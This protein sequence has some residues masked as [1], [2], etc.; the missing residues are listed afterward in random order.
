ME[1]VNYSQI[2]SKLTK[3]LS[4][5][6]KGIFDKRFGVNPGTAHTLEAIGQKLGITRERVRQIEE[7]G[8]NYIRK[9]NKELLDK[10][11]LQ[12]ESYFDANGG[13]KKE[14]VLMAEL[15]GEKN[16]PY[17]LF[18]LSIGNQ[19]NKACEKKENY[20]FWVAHPKNESDIKGT[21]NALVA[22]IK[23]HGK[24]LSKNE[25]AEK[26]AQKYNLSHQAVA[27]YVEVS[28][29]I[30]STKD[31]KLGLTDW[32]EIRPRGV[33]DKAFLVFQKHQKPLHF[34]QIA[35]LIGELDYNG[36]GTKAHAQTVHNELIKD[37]RFVLVGR[38]MYALAEWGYRPGTIKEVISRI[39][40][41]KPQ[42]ANQ[43]EIVKEVL[44]QRMVAKNTVLINLNNKKYF[45]KDA[46][47]R[48]TQKVQES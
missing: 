36:S 17:V 47:G 48:Y 15:A 38:G 21:L 37:P 28:K 30:Q 45:A 46:E 27:S 44:S 12:I 33:K 23:G 14:S 40:K 42:L 1:K 29:R 22:D 16:K 5:K 20:D 3:G 19:F 2:Y 43:E 35:D 39:L 32:P 11:L 34:K 41:E 24:L 13:F 26:F 9:N 8:F 25:L 4:P 7:A 6:I 18:L 31:G 10:M